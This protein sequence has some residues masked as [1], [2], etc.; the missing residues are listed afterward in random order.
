MFR[1]W[2]GRV[3]VVLWVATW[4]AG[5][6]ARGTEIHVPCGVSPCYATI[7]AAINAPSTVDGDVII[8]ANDTYNEYELDF[9]GKAITLRSASDDP[10]LCTID[11][12][13][14]PDHLRRA[15]WFHSGESP[16]AVI[17]SLTIRNGYTR[18][19]N[20]GELPGLGA[21]PGG[22]I[23]CQ[24]SS[25]TIINCV[26][27]G[28]TSYDS[29]GA[30]GC[31]VDSAPLLSHCV[32]SLNTSGGSGG[33]I[34]CMDSTILITNSI[35]NDNVAYWDGGGVYCQNASPVIRHTQIMSNTSSYG[36]GGGG[37]F[38][39]QHSNCI[40]SNCLVGENSAAAWG[41]GIY[42]AGTSYLSLLN[43]TIAENDADSYGG[44][45]GG[46]DS[47]MQMTRCIVWDND[48]DWDQVYASQ[49]SLAEYSDVADGP[50]NFW[51][52]GLTC[53]DD[54]PEFYRP[55]GLPP[56]PGPDP[57][58][59]RYCL[60]LDPL[61]WCVDWPGLDP[62]TAKVFGLDEY[63][64]R[65]DRGRDTGLVDLGYHYPCDRWPQGNPPG[66]DVPDTLDVI[67]DPALDCNANGIADVFDI[68]DDPS[69]D[70]DQ[71]GII[72]DCQGVPQRAAFSGVPSGDKK[73][74]QRGTLINV[75]IP[76]GTNHLQ[77]CAFAKP[78]PYITVAC[79]PRGTVARFL[80]EEVL[81]LGEEGAFLGEYATGPEGAVSDPSRTAVDLD[82]NTWVSNRHEDSPSI[83]KFGVV[84][85]GTRCD[86][87]GREDDD[88]EYIKPP[89]DL[90]AGF[91]W[92][93]TV[94]DRDEDDLIH[95][96]G[97][98]YNADLLG[99]AEDECLLHYVEVSA[100]GTR[101][102]CVTGENNVWVS[103]TKCGKAQCEFQLVNGETGA[104]QSGSTFTPSYGGLWRANRL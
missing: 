52:D 79:S 16:A 41:A 28:N 63:T 39:S 87:F 60:C 72:D 42:L 8:V 17:R 30:L 48:P 95:T 3:T 78:L 38:L 84:L 54:D 26:L 62:W 80:T 85:G 67:L 76:Q 45:Y 34:G 71:N 33:G 77:R 12:A 61:S 74:F 88:G 25:P 99:W 43:C 11:C 70:M 96:H 1:S 31:L 19:L 81:G 9:H 36:D 27:T 40:L 83:A 92:Y 37:I 68:L 51:Y 53:E 7:A 50:G 46:D 65:Y 64:T 94:I 104:I 10:T 56:A 18:G 98:L 5:N 22:A 20:P 24:G 89:A 15:L 59:N 55:N 100:R 91:P 102:V 6:D 97:R 58:N 49:D 4:V 57:W 21:G 75:E 66:N 23:L 93:N 69:L 86:F 2:C 32:V 13:G 14:D 47:P 29:G 82:G 101:H 73:S 44:L 35:V 90:S 103:G